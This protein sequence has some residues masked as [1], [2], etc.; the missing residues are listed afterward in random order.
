[1]RAAADAVAMKKG[2]RHFRTAR[3][4]YAFG[5]ADPPPEI[6]LSYVWV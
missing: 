3:P 5:G 2:A 4:S 1:M 6:G